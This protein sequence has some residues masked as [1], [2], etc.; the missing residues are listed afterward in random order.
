MT[1]T[2]DS[3]ISPAVSTTQSHPWPLFGLL[4]LIVVV[5]LSIGSWYLLAD[6]QTSPWDFYPLPFNAALFWS[7]VFIVFIGFNC[8]FAGFDRIPQPWR[9][10]VV[11]VSTA[12]FGIAATWLLSPGLGELYPDFASDREAGLGYFAG[13][14]FVLFG[15]G[16]WVMAA[17][18]WNHWPWTGLGMKQPLAG[19]CEIAFVAIPTLALYFTLGLP[20]VSLSATNPLMSIDTVLGWFYSIVVCV[21]FTGQTLDNWPWR[22]FASSSKR[23]LMPLTATI[24]NAALGT[25]LYFVMVSV[26]KFLVGQSNVDELGAVINQFPAQIGVCWVLWMVLW[27]NAFGNWPTRYGDSVNFAVRAVVTLT[28]GVA[29]F[30]FYYKFAAEHI[31]HEPPIAGSLYGNALGFIDWLVLWT[32]LYV[33][34]FQSW[35]LRRLTPAP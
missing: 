21:I 25:A 11:L 35:G 2:V 3:A 5:A 15:F 23:W 34:G 33:V 22:S 17:L 32:L 27:A 31:L 14:L 24:G 19:L 18:N 30:L 7:I 9:G 6:P 8:E 13:A 16:T 4:N 10:S 28:L 26:A 1:T 12:L 29:T 20:A